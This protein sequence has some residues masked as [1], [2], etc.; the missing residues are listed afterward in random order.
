MTQPGMWTG[1]YRLWASA[2]NTV[3]ASPGHEQIA[4]KVEQSCYLTACEALGQTR[5]SASDDQ[6]PDLKAWACV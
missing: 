5:L 6:I 4:D 2:R 1:L 3:Q